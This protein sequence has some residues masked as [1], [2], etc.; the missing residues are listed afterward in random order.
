MDSDFLRL[1]EDVSEFVF[2]QFCIC[3]D[4]N[5]EFVRITLIVYAITISRLCHWDRVRCC[6]RGPLVRANSFSNHEELAHESSVFF[7]RRQPIV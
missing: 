5:I 2:K 7:V 1:P 3:R 6:S 4:Y